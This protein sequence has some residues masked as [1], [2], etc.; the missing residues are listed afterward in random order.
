LHNAG[1]I[2]G[3]ASGVNVSEM[4]GLVKLDS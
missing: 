4:V 3:A 2:V 1:T